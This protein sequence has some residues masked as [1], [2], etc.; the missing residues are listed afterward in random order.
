MQSSLKTQKKYTGEYLYKKQKAVRKN[1]GSVAL[2]LTSNALPLFGV[3]NNRPSSPFLPFSSSLPFF[4]LY[5]EQF[6]DA[7]AAVL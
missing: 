7:A 1:E 4:L 2:N 6:K 3:Q 5:Q